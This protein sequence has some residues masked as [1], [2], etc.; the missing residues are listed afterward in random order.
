MG[1]AYAMNNIFNTASQIYNISKDDI[2][3]N[4]DS[5]ISIMDSYFLA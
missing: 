1:K 2:L 4:M 3:V 5:D